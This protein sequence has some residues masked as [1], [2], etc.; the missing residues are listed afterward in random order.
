MNASGST[1]QFEN[2]SCKAKVLCVKERGMIPPVFWG[3][4]L[5]TAGSRGIA[6]LGQA[7]KWWIDLSSGWIRSWSEGA[8]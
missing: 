5:A 4:K 6:E 8:D 1:P 3:P 2:A 7:E